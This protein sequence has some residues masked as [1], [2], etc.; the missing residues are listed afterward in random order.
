MAK[1]NKNNIQKIG[2]M[3]KG[4]HSSQKRVSS[5]FSDARSMGDKQI[6]R[7]DGEIWAEKDSTGE[8]ICWW[9]LK[10]GVKVKTSFHPDMVR[11][12]RELRNYLNTFPNCPKDKCTCISPTSL[13]RKFQR[14]TGMCEDCTISYETSLKLNGKFNEYAIDR[15]LKN[16]E[17]YFADADKEIEMLKMEMKT[18]DFINSERGDIEKWE[19]DDVDEVIEK[20]DKYYNDYK[21]NVLKKLKGEYHPAAT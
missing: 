12:F 6:D 9:E 3:V 2:Q 16:A 21:V 4:E 1:R 11:K 7:S 5:G 19:W 18:T 20:F 13:D 15:M 8:I 10:D 17:G 14:R